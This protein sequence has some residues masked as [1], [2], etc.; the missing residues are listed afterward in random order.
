M[1]GI[2]LQSK[3][4]AASRFIAPYASILSALSLYVVVLGIASQ[5]SASL[6]D[7]L[8][9]L[10]S[11]FLCVVLQILLQMGFGYLFAKWMRYSDIESRAVLFEVGICNSALATVL[12]NDTFGSMAGMAAMANTVCNLTLGSLLAAILSAIPLRSSSS[13][14][15]KD[16]NK[17]KISS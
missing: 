14:S 2:F 16:T 1:V 17:E 13:V 9:I 4:P 12:A 11:L 6:I 5:A 15:L 10:P 3:I 7:N 8:T